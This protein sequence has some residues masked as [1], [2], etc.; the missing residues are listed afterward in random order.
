[1]TPNGIAYDDLRRFLAFI[2]LRF[3]RRRWS[4][5]LLRELQPKLLFSKDQG[6]S[7]SLHQISQYYDLR[8]NSVNYIKFSLR[9]RNWSCLFSMLIREELLSLRNF[10]DSWP[11]WIKI[12]EIP[13]CEAR[14]SNCCLH[15]GVLITTVR[16]WGRQEWENIQH[17]I[18]APTRINKAS[19]LRFVGFQYSRV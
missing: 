9:L 3:L 1:M 5:L 11:A 2:K 7:L 17:N 18:L 16:W 15:V 12:P 4:L 8:K 19:K 6:R 10:V 14:L 13:I